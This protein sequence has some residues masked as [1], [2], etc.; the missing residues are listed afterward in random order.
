M[1][2]SKIYSSICTEAAIDH[3]IDEFTEYLMM[4]KMKLLLSPYAV[5]QALHLNTVTCEYS[6]YQHDD[7]IFALDQVDE[8]WEGVHASYDRAACDNIKTNRR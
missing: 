5:K 3:L 2:D 8:T 6:L 1:N 7:K 4:Q